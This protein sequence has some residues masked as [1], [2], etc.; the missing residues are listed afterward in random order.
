MRI[1]L[2]VLQLITSL[3][4]IGSILLQSGKDA[5]LSGSITGGAE[6]LWGKQGRGYEGMLSKVTAIGAVLFIIVAILL[7]AIQ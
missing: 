4:L 3:V 2:M 7:V 5:G 6:Q 1:V